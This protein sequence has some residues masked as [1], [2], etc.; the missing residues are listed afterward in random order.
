MVL[1]PG[2]PLGTAPDGAAP[3]ESTH[4]MVP[5]EQVVLY[6]DGLVERREEDIS[7]GLDR[8]LRTATGVPDPGVLCDRLS[9]SAV[10]PPPRTTPA[11]W[12]CAAT[13]DR[14]PVRRTR[15]CGCG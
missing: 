13:P 8:M 15:C 3:E 5:G 9:P 11:S 6:S 4:V 7:D 12:C 2:P 1:E 14:R 10:I